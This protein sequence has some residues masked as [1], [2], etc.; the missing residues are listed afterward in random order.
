MQKPKAKAFS[1]DNQWWVKVCAEGHIDTL[2]ENSFEGVTITNY[3]D[4]T[5]AIEGRLADL[6]AVYGFIIRLRD[7]LIF[8]HSLQVARMEIEDKNQ[9]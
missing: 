9:S 3:D 5:A 4:G 6:P 2:L 7:T 1:Q 8:L